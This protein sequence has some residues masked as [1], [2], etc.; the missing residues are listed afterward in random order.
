[1]RSRGGKHGGWPA[2][3]GAFAPPTPAA[4]V[5]VWAGI[6]CTVNRVHDRYLDQFERSGHATRP[7]D[8]DRLAALGVR[9]LRYPLLWERIDLDLIRTLAERLPEWQVVM[10]G[11]V[12]KMAPPDLPQAP[13]THWRGQKQ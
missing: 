7:S 13:N 1:M 2:A 5:E 10:A 11:P 4:P 9:A 8:L 6:E 12:V 3:G